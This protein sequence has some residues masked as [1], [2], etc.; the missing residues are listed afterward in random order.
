M[1]TFD[2]RCKVCDYKFEIFHIDRN[3]KPKCPK[4]G[5]ETIRLISAPAIDPNQ[6]IINRMQ[7]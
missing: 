6:M 2:Y 1:P 7:K 3:H 5:G 4:C